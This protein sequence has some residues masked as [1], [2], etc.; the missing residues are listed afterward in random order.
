MNYVEWMAKHF[1][2]IADAIDQAGAYGYYGNDPITALE[3]CNE[4]TGSNEY[5]GAIQEWYDYMEVI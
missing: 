2:L 4:N 3:I 5:E 1:E